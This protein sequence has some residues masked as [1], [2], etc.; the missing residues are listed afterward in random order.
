VLFHHRAAFAGDHAGDYDFDEWNSWR[1]EDG[2]LCRENHD[3]SWIDT[4]LKC[5]KHEL[6]Y[7]PEV[8]YIHQFFKDESRVTKIQCFVIRG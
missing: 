8:N 5:D 6:H 7:T 4:N 1:K 3:C 2:M